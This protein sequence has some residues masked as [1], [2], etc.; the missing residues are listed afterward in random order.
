MAALV[1]A[2]ERL[3]KGDNNDRGCWMSEARMY[4]DDRRLEPADFEP[5]SVHMDATHRCAHV[6]KRQRRNPLLR[7]HAT[8][9]PRM[10]WC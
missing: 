4:L 2:V 3:A 6:I 8:G 10:P 7:N 5:G 1:E 9:K